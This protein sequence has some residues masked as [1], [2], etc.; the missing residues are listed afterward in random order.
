M[1][2]LGWGRMGTSDSKIAHFLDMSVQGYHLVPLVNKDISP[3][4]WLSL[5][6]VN[7]IVEVAD[8]LRQTV[9]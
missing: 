3:K 9:G 4:Y 8:H 1:V 5:D 7:S 6:L 2:V